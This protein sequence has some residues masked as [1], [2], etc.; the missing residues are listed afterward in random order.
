VSPAGELR[1]WLEARRDAMVALLVGL[2]RLESPSTDAGA[3]APVMEALTA[4]LEPAGYRARRRSGTT[5]GG[6]L[7]LLRSDRARS[8]PHQLLLGHCDTVWATGTLAAMPVEVEGDIVRGP[9]TFDMKAGLVLGVFAL[10]ALEALGC[11]PGVEPAF[12]VTSDEEVGS[13]DSLRWIRALARTA[14]RVLVLEPAAGP[15]GLVKTARKGVADLQLITRG[16]AAHAGLDPDVGASAIHEMARLVPRVLAT[17]E[18]LKGV[19]LNVGT[20]E[21]GERPNVIADEC[22]AALDVRFEHLADGEEVE[23]RI[24][25]LRTETRG[26]SLEVTGG[27]DRP[28]LERTEANRRLWKILRERAREVGVELE[29]APVVGG[30]SDGNHTSPLAPTIDGLGP[31][32]AGAHA[33]HEHVLAASLPERAAVLANLLLAPAVRGAGGREGTGAGA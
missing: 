7:L 12:L 11:T 14:D 24:R 9:G 23:A 18:G 10:R 28:P 15:T 26:T 29:E 2:A 25:A 30:G 1:A 5:S 33:D 6:V 17:R 21:G 27:I 4:A 22:R 31:V 3:Q 32:G 16:V 19:T 13:Q 8:A 20:I